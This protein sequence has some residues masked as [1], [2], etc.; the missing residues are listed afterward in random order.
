MLTAEDHI[1][2][3][4]LYAAYNQYIDA[5]RIDEWLAVFTPDGELVVGDD[6]VG[7]TQA[8]RAFGLRRSEQQASMPFRNAQHWN[9]NLLLDHDGDVVR[10]SCYLVRFAV[11]RETGSKAVVSMGSYRDEIVRHEAEWLFSRREAFPL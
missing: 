4:R 8:L 6:V 10:G 11:D 1:A 5:D 3:E 2:I 9:T 7:G